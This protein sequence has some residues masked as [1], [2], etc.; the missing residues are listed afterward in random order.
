MRIFFFGWDHLKDDHAAIASKLQRSGHEILYWTTPSDETKI[1]IARFSSIIFHNIVEASWGKGAPRI[2]ATNFE[3]PSKNLIE[4]MRNTEALVL[5]M[6]N[7]RFDWMC[8]DERRH[9]Y[10]NL[11]QYWQGVLKKYAPDIIIFINIPHTVYDYVVYEMAKR[12]NIKTIMFDDILIS[13]RLL[14]INDFRQG[15]KYL[16][17]Y[18]YS[19]N[20][21]AE[22]L[23]EDL[24][25]YYKKQTDS[26]VDS[27]PGYVKQ[28]FKQN[29]LRNN[30]LKK[31]KAVKQGIEDR[32]IFRKTYEYFLKLFG[33]NLMKDY[34]N[35][36]EIP[37]LN[38]K[39][40]YIPL[41]YQPEC[42]SSPMA[43]VF[44]DQI[45]MIETV[46]SSIPNDWIIYVKEH[47]IQWLARGLNYYSSRYKGYYKKIASI[48]RVK[49]IPVK[50]NNYEL[51][52]A[53][54]VVVTATG[55]TALEAVLRSK[56]AVVFGYPWYQNCPSLLRA[57]DTRSCREAID[58]VV[59]GL[60]IS[61]QEVINFI[62]ALEK[63]TIKGYLSSYSES[64]SQLS[65]REN[66]DNISEVLLREIGGI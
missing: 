18:D 16:V 42:T 8:A 22:D 52:G 12:A 43:D 26:S 58:K 59:Q 50:T 28:D 13:D 41:N 46:A 35:L 40:V 4:Q 10:Y 66:A 6:M 44:A 55:T 60:S 17:D 19:Q 65:W 27:T 54:L 31:A 34:Q 23:S 14:L 7:K 3:A 37:D 20:Y 62:K 57:H 33:D 48:P 21:V 9:L 1:D 49:I 15:G 39:F 56:P 29:T 63:N 11:L 36:Q 25:S 45:L 38:K 24:K 2:D 64:N 47:P 61:Q 53:S 5:T 30:F 32:S 51:I